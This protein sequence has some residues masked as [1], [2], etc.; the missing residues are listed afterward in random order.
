MIDT[1]ENNISNAASHN[2][3]SDKVRF[4]TKIVGDEEKRF[5][6]TDS[7]ES[8]FKNVLLRL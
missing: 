2:G 4:F 6:F 7:Q 8:T 1:V 3:F 5:F